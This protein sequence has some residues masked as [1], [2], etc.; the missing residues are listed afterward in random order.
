MI[1]ISQQHLQNIYNQ[2]ENTY[3]QECCGIIIGHRQ[4]NTKI[5]VKI[6]CT[7]NVWNSDESVNFP[8][9]D[10][11]LNQKMGKTRRYAIAPLDMLQAQK[12]ARDRNMDIIG[13]YH[14]HPD[15]QAIPSEFDRNCAWQEYSYIIVS[16][17]QGKID[18]IQSWVL[19]ENH[20][21]QKENIK[22]EDIKQLEDIEKLS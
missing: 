11:T 1:E 21:F 2:A 20:Q 14:S 19:D 4:E 10:V 8:S 22:L 13:I 6:I 17:I 3:P 5:V 18:D 9:E 16:V 12:S 7:E 15:Y